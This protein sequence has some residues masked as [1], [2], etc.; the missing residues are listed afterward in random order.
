MAEFFGGD[1]HRAMTQ[2]GNIVFSALVPE[3]SLMCLISISKCVIYFIGFTVHT[4][5]TRNTV[6]HAN[7]ISKLAMITSS[8][9]VLIPSAGCGGVAKNINLIHSFRIGF[10]TSVAIF[11]LEKTRPKVFDLQRIYSYALEAD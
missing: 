4:V 3:A 11:Y 5:L 6:E 10:K 7:Q 1:G 9:S 2:T 8:F